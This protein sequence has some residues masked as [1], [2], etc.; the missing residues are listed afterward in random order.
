MYFPISI[1]LVLK[2]L[3]SHANFRLQLT[4]TKFLKYNFNSAFALWAN[5]ELN[6]LVPSFSFFLSQSLSFFLHLA[7]SWKYLSILMP[8]LWNDIQSL[9]FRVNQIVCMFV[10]LLFGLLTYCNEA[11]IGISPVLDEINSWYFFRHSWDVLHYFQIITNFCSVCQSVSWL[12]S[13]LKLGR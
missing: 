11:N 5:T 9:R 13:L 7:E 8:R 4:R 10:N 12:T 2:H 6:L 3:F 1:F